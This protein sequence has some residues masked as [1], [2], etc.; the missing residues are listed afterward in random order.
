[1]PLLASVFLTERE[2]WVET[3]HQPLVVTFESKPLVAKENLF[4]RASEE[5][6]LVF[7]NDNNH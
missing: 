7:W 1:M 5:Y 4:S 2:P 3:V 6:T